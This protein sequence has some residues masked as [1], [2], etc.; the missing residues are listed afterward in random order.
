MF[1]LACHKKVGFGHVFIRWVKILLKN[2]ESCMMKAGIT[3]SYFN[4]EKG[5]R[6]GDPISAYPTS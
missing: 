6:Q 4:L 1:L 2:Q 3:K 5:A